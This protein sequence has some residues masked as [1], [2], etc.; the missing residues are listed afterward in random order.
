[1]EPAGTVQDQKRIDPGNGMAYTWEEFKTFYDWTH[2]PVEVEA[3]WEAC[4]DELAFFD[5][6][7]IDSE[8]PEPYGAVTGD[9]GPEGV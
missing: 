5:E 9:G 4:K 6:E 3:Y 7:G 2:S 1:M 8:H